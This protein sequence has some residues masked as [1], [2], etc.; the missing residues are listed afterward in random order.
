MQLKSIEINERL[1]TKNLPRANQ[2]LQEANAKIQEKERELA[3]Y[4]KAE[5]D[6]P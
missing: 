2:L 5:K 6:L 1:A 3:R 4:R